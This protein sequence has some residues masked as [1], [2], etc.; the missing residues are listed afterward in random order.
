MDGIKVKPKNL[1]G[2]L[3]GVL[4]HER[5]AAKKKTEEDLWANNGLK[6]PKS[7]DG[8]RMA[9]TSTIYNG[10]EITEYRLYKLLDSARVTIGAE[11]STKV[12]H[13]IVDGKTV[14]N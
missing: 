3:L 9:E 12:E 8:Y 13:G 6:D 10:A 2:S 1:M 7:R 5:Y 4:Q 11:V 14:T